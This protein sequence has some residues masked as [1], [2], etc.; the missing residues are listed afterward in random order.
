MRRNVRARSILVMVVGSVA[1]T[2]ITVWAARMIEVTATLAESCPNCA[3]P[4]GGCPYGGALCSGTYSLLPPSSTFSYS[5]S[6][7]VESEIL[8]HNAVYTLDTTNT[9]DGGLVGTNTVTVKMLFYAPENV[10]AALPGCWGFGPNA[11]EG[12]E[13]QAVNWSIFS[14]NSMP[15]TNMVTG[16][17]Y[18]GHARLDFN[19][20]NANCDSQIFRYYLTWSSLTIMREGPTTWQVTSAGACYSGL[21]CGVASLYGQGGRHGQTQYYGDWRMPFQITLAQ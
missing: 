10:G 4:A 1:L 8:N 3:T 18:S 21:N 5:P 19:V 6:S 9:L 11:N 13:T 16:I 7:S 2:A 14:E 12:S 20:R 15:F 17:P